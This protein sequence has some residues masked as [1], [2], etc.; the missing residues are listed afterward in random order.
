ME[1]RTNIQVYMHGNDSSCAKKAVF[2]LK[3]Q[4]SHTKLWTQL[5]WGETDFLWKHLFFLLFNLNIKIKNLDKQN[6]N[7]EILQNNCIPV[8]N[9]VDKSVAITASI[10]NVNHR[11]VIHI[12]IF[13]MLNHCI[14]N[15]LLFCAKTDLWHW[16][17]N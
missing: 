3:K 1:N 14:S 13:G 16:I 8:T 7:K 11:I 4:F 10:E 2:A 12:Y 6:G 5:N 15:S 9:C 17:Y